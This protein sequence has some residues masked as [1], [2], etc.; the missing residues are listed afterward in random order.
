MAVDESFPKRQKIGMESSSRLA[1]VGKAVD[2]ILNIDLEDFQTHVGHMDFDGYKKLLE[3]LSGLGQAMKDSRPAFSNI[4]VSA[5]VTNMFHYLESRTDWNSFALVTK[6]INKAVMEHKDIAPPWPECFLIHESIDQYS[7]PTFSHV[8]EFI[9]YGNYGGYICLWSRKKGLVERWRGHSNVSSVSFS[10]CSN[11]LVSIGSDNRIKLWDL[12]NRNLCVW[13][14]ANTSRHDKVAFSPTGDIIAT[15][16]YPDARVFVRS[17]SDGSILQ[18]LRSDIGIKYGVAFSP[19]GRTLAVCGYQ[20]AIELWDLDNDSGRS[21]STLFDGHTEDVLAIA[22]SPDGKFLVSASND[23]T[24][25]LWDVAKEKC[26][27]NLKGHIGRVR[28][29]SFS[30]DG[31]FLASGSDDREIRVWSMA[32]GNCVETIKATGDVFSVEF[33]YDG[34]ILLTKEGRDGIRL[35]HLHLL[36]HA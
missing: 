18:T 24:L 35:R 26:V 20:N 9:A 27:Q 34:K 11:L 3:R 25:K 2:T 13:T 10:P 6:E 33:S 19:D 4:P 16:G 17:K 36:G 21:T 14:Q 30:P 8:G 5:V 29:V 23:K 7:A 28:S 12:D 1:Q 22:Y 31:K 15:F 32:N